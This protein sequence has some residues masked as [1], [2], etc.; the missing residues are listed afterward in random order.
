ME[1]KKISTYKRLEKVYSKA[2]ILPLGKGLKYVLMSDCH[3]GVGTWNDNFLL[4][5]NLFF[6]ALQEY[7]RC[8][9]TYI[10]LGDGDELWENRSFC[11]IRNMHTQVFELLSRYYKEGRFYAVYGNHDIV[12]RG[13]LFSATQCKTCYCEKTLSEC[14]LFPDISFYSGIILENEDKKCGKN[15]EK[16]KKIAHIFCSF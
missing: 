5:Q 4:N 12:K 11:A 3:R 1:D 6:A 9:Y 16:C 13:K 8:G 14:A 10:E 7:Y 15:V 2:K